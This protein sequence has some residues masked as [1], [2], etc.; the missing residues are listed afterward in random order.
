MTSDGQ[1]KHGSKGIVYLA[2]VLGI[3]IIVV[4]GF[5]APPIGCNTYKSPQN[6][7]TVDMTIGSKTYT[8]EVAAND[9]TRE[10]GLMMRDKMP[11]NWGM[12]FVFPDEEPRSFWMRNTRIP[13]DIIYVSAG[14]KVM[15]IKQM[16][17][18]DETPVPSDGV[19]KYA[20]ELNLNQAAA[21]GVKVG[22]VLV[23]PAAAAKTDQ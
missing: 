22:D 9:L 15:S 3:A 20:I 1:P 8:L 19:A 2:G 17:A 14:G 4:V 18:Y 6:L 11:G 5:L 16:K 21:T 7:A 10:H 12:I 23:I 13:L